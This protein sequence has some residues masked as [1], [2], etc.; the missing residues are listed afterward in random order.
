MSEPLPT[1]V[2]IETLRNHTGETVVIKNSLLKHIASKLEI[3][4]KAS[5]SMLLKI[6]ELEQS[7]KGGE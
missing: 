3:Y 5:K 2:L 1:E 6:K 4:Q 7:L